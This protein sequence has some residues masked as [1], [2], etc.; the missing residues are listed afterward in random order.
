MHESTIIQRALLTVYDKTHIVELAEALHLRGVELIS[1]GNTAALL[2]Q[3]GIPVT[4]VGEYTGFP[5][6][7]DG[8]VKTLH[9]KIHGGILGRRDIDADIMISHGIPDIDLVVVNL[10]P[11]EKVIQKEQ[12]TSRDAIEN[13]DIGGPTLIRGAA[14]NHE[15]CTV[16]VDPNDYNDFIEDLKA[17]EGA[18]SEKTRIHFAA[19]AFAHTASYEAHIADYFNK[20]LDKTAVQFGSTFIMPHHLKETLRYGENPHQHA[21]FYQSF[22]APKDSIAKAISHQGKTLSF[23]NIADANTALECVKSFDGM[24]CVIVKHANPCGVAKA[25]TALEAYNMA[26]ACDPQSAFGG[27]IAFNT[28]VD[29]K[30]MAHILNK[31]FVEVII[32]PGYSEKALENAKN[33]PDCRILSYQKPTTKEPSHEWD[34]HSVCGGLLVQTCDTLDNPVSYEIVTEQKPTPSQIADLLFSWQVVKFVKSNAIVF[35]KNGQTLGIGAGQMSRIMSTQIAAIRA[36]EQNLS[37]DNAV[38]ASDAFFPFTDNI[39]KAYEYGIRAVIQPGGS[40]KDPEVIA[41]ANALGMVMLLTGKRHF[42][43]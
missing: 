37:L 41:K 32:A 2:Q 3:H 4:P 8:R 14:K 25:N 33:K 12:V 21:A 39:E 30:L 35:A 22:N 9:P 42:R 34:V 16:L 7:M 15:W 28:E 1:T 38:M 29:D 5:E 20:Q 10:Y 23:N 18:V 24:A 26:Y 27:I 17:N 19:K 6:M 11:F 36:K 40:K 31:Q 43:H 13:I